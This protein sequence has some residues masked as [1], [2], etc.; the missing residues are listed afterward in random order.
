VDI[1][2]GNV[3]INATDLEGE[4]T[5]GQFLFA[6]NFSASPSTGGNIECNAST[7]DATALVNKTST[8]IVG[9]VLAAGNFTKED[10]TAQESIYLC[11]RETGF[12][13]SPQQYS[14][15][16][17]GDWTIRI[18]LVAITPARRRKK[19]EKKELKKSNKV[20]KLLIKLTDELRT[21]YSREKEMITK[22]L[23]RAV[24][25]EYGIKRRE[26]LSLIRKDIEIP[27]EIFSKKLGALE[28]LTKYMKENLNMNYK[29]IAERLG[30]DER[31]IWTA[32]KKAT[33][34][35][36]GPFRIKGVKMYLP[37]SIFEDRELTAL[38]SII[39]Y[40]KEKGM[41]YSEIAELLERDQRNIWTIYSRVKK[42]LRNKYK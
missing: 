7:T 33:E 24:Q 18:L 12:E 16:A 14:T 23:I 13:L 20:L 40:L 37:M 22:Q 41:K 15:N 31:T 9:S 8:G 39:K 30:R 26:V 4:T 6:A 28:V 38:E 27:T 36:K 35:Q 42:K 19:K 32:Y 10:G 2:S 21:E 17:F 5:S 25:E 3:Q 11:L 1:A 29:E 34:K